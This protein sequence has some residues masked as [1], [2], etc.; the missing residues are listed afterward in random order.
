M[1]AF[2]MLIRALTPAHSKIHAILIHA[3]TV[4]SAF[5]PV[6]SITVF[7]RPHTQVHSA[8]HLSRHQ[9]Y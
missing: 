6:H 8:Q 2:W 5:R 4:V 3:R 7:V 9:V 1:V